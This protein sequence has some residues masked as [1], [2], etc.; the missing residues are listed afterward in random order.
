M[1]LEYLRQF[2]CIA[3]EGTL[4]KAAE[5]LLL[6]QST[7]TRNMFHLEEI[8]DV[9]LFERSPNRIH[10]TKTGQYALK[11]FKDLIEEHNHTIQNIRLYQ[12]RNL[13][14]RGGFCAQGPLWLMQKL[15]KEKQVSQDTHYEADFQ[16]Q[17]ESELLRA[18]LYKKY[19]FIV[20][21]F[22]VKEKRI[23]SRYFFAEQ[24][25]L[26]VPENHPLYEKDSLHFADLKGQNLILRKEIGIWQKVVDQLPYIHFISEN[27]KKFD[28]LIGL[29][30]LPSFTT[31]ISQQYALGD[32]RKNIKILDE[33][34][35]KEYFLSFLEKNQGKMEGV[36][37]VLELT[38]NYLR[39]ELVN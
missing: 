1:K 24:L 4:S 8:L 19:D 22:P 26:S 28:R 34:A 2:I 3:E 9:Q 13:L 25:Y 32:K 14:L 16:L 11:Q 5:K 10:L 30:S 38:R 18:L 36:L 6:S 23:D 20:T 37:A 7:L 12:N 33:D 35:R 17:E 27:R 21:C 15:Y 31:N 29:F 39:N